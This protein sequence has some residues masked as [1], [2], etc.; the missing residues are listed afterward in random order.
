MIIGNE[1]DVTKAVLSELERAPNPRFREI[2]S[3]FVRHLH[4]FAR[5]VQLTEQEFQTAIV[6][7]NALGKHSNENHNEAVLM[8]G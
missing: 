2:I 6:Y 4:D 5:E 8:A 1:Q 3:A 7:I